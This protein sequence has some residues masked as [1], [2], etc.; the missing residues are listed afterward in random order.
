MIP[1]DYP[2]EFVSRTIK[3]MEE[4]Y[5]EIKAKELEVTFLLNCLLGLIIATNE[6]TENS[7]YFT[8]T[9]I[10]NEE[11]KKYIP[12]SIAQLNTSEL[13][14]SIKNLINEKSLLNQLNAEIELNNKIKID[15]SE[16]LTNLS[17]KQFIRK[18]RNGIA[19]QNL[20]PTSD[21]DHWKGIRIWNHNTNGIKDFE[22]EFTISELKNFALF[23]G[24]KFIEIK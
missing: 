7:E 3:L 15:K 9:L 23:V 22:V 6:S 14:K 20:M 24:N 10:T 16:Q 21:N 8:N 4:F 2:T 13:N 5:S 12:K 1:H 19:H 11:I 17:L 18:I